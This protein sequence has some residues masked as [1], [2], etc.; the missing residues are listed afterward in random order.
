MDGA[1]AGRKL[2][3]ILIETVAAGAY[4]LAVVGIGLNVQPM[5]VSDASTGFASLQELDSAATAPGVLRR[6]ALPLVLAL[7]QFEREGFAAFGAGFSAR[8]LL[9]GQ[10]VRTTQPDVPE[11]IAQ[12]VSAQGA[13][14][15]QTA[16]GLRPVSSGEV[17]VR[18]NPPADGTAA[19][20]PDA[21]VRPC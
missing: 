8:D 12:G 9:R 15:V 14:L 21:L 5:E 10:P 7:R 17:S 11:G 6:V 19:S 18:L 13:L 3:G 4:R 16:A 2:G 1:G 20:E